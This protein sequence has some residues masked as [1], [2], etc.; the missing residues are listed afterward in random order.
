MTLKTMGLHPA[1]WQT[2]SLLHSPQAELGERE[3]QA[4]TGSQEEALLGGTE[5]RA[6]SCDRDWPQKLAGA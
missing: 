1:S 6:G 2:C 5:R 3:S 4:V